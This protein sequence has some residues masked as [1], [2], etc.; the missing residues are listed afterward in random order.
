MEFK[1]FQTLMRA[2]IKHEL[3]NNVSEK[4]SE[5]GFI[6]HKKKKIRIFELKINEGGTSND[7]SSV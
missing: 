4:P 1:P 3:I 5:L 6:I 7:G 2:S